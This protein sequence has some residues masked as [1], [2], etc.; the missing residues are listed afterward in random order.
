MSRSSKAIADAYFKALDD[1]GDSL[2][3]REGGFYDRRCHIWR[4]EKNAH[5]EVVIVSATTLDGITDPSGSL[6]KN[7]NVEI[8]GEDND[9]YVTVHSLGDS[10]FKN[11]DVVGIYS[12]RLEVELVA[13]YKPSVNFTKA[14]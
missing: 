6:F 10:Q 1:L 14:K 7:V 5:G 9:S 8:V 2:G 13:Q 11:V 4:R 12:K 3:Q